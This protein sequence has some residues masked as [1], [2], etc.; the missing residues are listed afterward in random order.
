[1]AGVLAQVD[2]LKMLVEHASQE[3]LMVHSISL[4]REFYAVAGRAVT[5][6]ETIVGGRC[7]D[8]VRFVHLPSFPQVGD[9]C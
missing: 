6:K 8:Q 9:D 7:Y 4:K 5:L 2:S 3:S 1:V